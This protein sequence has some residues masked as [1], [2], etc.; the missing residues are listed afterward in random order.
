VSNVYVSLAT[1]REWQLYTFA[2]ES[3]ADVSSGDIGCSSSTSAVELLE[4]SMSLVLGFLE[5]F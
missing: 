1:I 3:T 4:E 2:G 5:D